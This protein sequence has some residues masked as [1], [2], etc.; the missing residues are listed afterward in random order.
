METSKTFNRGKLKRLAQ[1][2]KLEMVE[3]YNFDDMHGESRSRKVVPVKFIVRGEDGRLPMSRA[4]AVW[5]STIS[6][7]MLVML[8]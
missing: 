3:S 6:A 7:P 4:S 8:G 2:G 1:Q 5:L